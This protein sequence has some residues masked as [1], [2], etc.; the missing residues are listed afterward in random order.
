MNVTD[1][2][3]TLSDEDIQARLGPKVWLGT[4]MH[5][6]LSS[7]LSLRKME[8]ENPENDFVKMERVALRQSDAKDFHDFSV[9]QLKAYGMNIFD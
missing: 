1:R 2:I 9:E 8:R 5:Y 4:P 3:A 7:E 6:R